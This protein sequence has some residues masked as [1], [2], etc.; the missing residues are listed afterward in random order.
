M[1]VYTNQALIRRRL[2]WSVVYLVVSMGLLVGGFLLSLTELPLI[3]QYGGSL[4]AL[5][6]GLFFWSRNQVQLQRWGP[7]GRQDAVIVRSLRALDDRYHLLAFPDTS[8]PDYIVVGPMGVLVLVPRA[9]SGRI[10]CSGNQWRHEDPRPQLM[11]LLRWLSSGQP[12]GDPGAEVSRAA[13]RTRRH[14]AAILPDGLTDRMPIAGVVVFTH[15]EARLSLEGC[16]ASALTLRSLRGHVRRLP[17]ALSAGEVEDVT[18][19]LTSG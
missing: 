7:R 17:R 11:R 6:A 12:L 5:V 2:R 16:Q 1:R 10:V 4:A 18:S 14:L 13:E 8:L 9:I 3:A 15:P 19:V